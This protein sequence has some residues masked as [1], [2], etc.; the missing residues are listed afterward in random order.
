M[1]LAFLFVCLCVVVC[2]GFLLL[3]GGFLVSFSVLYCLF[4]CY[5]SGLLA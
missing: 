1:F 4:V 5:G 2:F 3:F